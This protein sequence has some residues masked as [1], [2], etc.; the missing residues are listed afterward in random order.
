M[1]WLLLLLIFDRLHFGLIIPKD[2]KCLRQAGRGLNIPMPLDYD[3]TCFTVLLCLHIIHMPIL[4]S[5]AGI[6]KIHCLILMVYLWCL[7]AWRMVLVIAQ[8]VSWINRVAHAT[9]LAWIYVIVDVILVNLHALLSFL[10]VSRF[11]IHIDW[12]V[13]KACIIVEI[14]I[15]WPLLHVEVH[16][17]AA[18][19]QKVF[20]IIAWRE[21]RGSAINIVVLILIRQTRFLLFLLFCLWR[22]LFDVPLFRWFNVSM[23]LLELDVL[24][25]LGISIIELSSVIWLLLI[26][27][28]IILKLASV[29]SGAKSSTRVEYVEVFV[30]FAL[31]A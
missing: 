23:L 16:H 8:A 20:L 9:D 12:C 6:I 4:D 26:H 22:H 30:Y 3:S 1:S 10:M 25:H 18:L 7:N 19:I 2:S 11:L 31:I 24:L 14:Q 13:V 17:I 28:L 5:G 27:K 15:N 29:T 21:N